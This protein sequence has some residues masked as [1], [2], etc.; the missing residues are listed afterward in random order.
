MDLKEKPILGSV[1]MNA[2][3]AAVGYAFHQS[4]ESA[5]VGTV[6][7]MGLMA[8]ARFVPNFQ[9]SR[10]DLPRVHSIGWRPMILSADESRMYTKFEVDFSESPL[11]RRALIMDEIVDVRVKA[12]RLGGDRVKRL[13]EGIEILEQSYNPSEDVAWRGIPEENKIEALRAIP[14][15]TS[16]SVIEPAVLAA[17][18]DMK[19]RLKIPV[20][21]N[22]TDINGV[23]QLRSANEKVSAGKPFDII[24]TAN[25]PLL[26]SEGGSGGPPIRDL[27]EF[28]LPIHHERQHL[29]RAKL[30]DGDKF[31]GLKGV[32]RVNFLGGS[33]CE[34]Q[35]LAL[36]DATGASIKGREWSISDLPGLSGLEGDQAAIV[37]DPIASRLLKSGRFVSIPGHRYSLWISMFALTDT[38]QQFAIRAALLNAFVS[39]W[40]FCKSNRP[41]AW[42]LLTGDNKISTAFGDALLRQV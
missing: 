40:V 37:Y 29:L 25:A 3:G 12:A 2:G 41:H 31:P 17:L 39:S 13:E 15:L 6:A 33:S 26:C 5:L 28:I 32:E 19:T 24:I 30:K 42:S 34:E 18:L 23:A 9:F 4:V 10:A 38:L 35:Y 16:C 7:G 21:I 22:Y 14:L 11:P 36:G 20:D 8:A 27:Y 1:L